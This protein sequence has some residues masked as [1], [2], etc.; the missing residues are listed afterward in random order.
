MNPLPPPPT[1]Q[2]YPDDAKLVT[3]D[4]IQ[5]VEIEE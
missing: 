1:P 2:D 3:A 5:P 4:C